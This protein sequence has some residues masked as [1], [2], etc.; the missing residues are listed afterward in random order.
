MEF[1]NLIK[2][3]FL[4]K[5]KL[6]KFLPTHEKIKEQKLLKIFGNFLH[7]R[8]IWS[9]SRKKVLG[10]VFIGIFV[11]CLPM[12]LQMVLASLLAIIFNVNLP[13]SFALIFITNPLTMPPLFFFEYQIGK[14]ILQPENPVEFNFDSMYDNF[15]DIAL[16]L[17]LG[18]IILG[19]ILA[20]VSRFIVNFLWIRTVRKDR[21]TSQNRYISEE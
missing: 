8:E 7:K 5:K 6:K 9:L 13:I 14:W 19:L 17:Y 20:F 18:S 4:P 15:D 10:G 11:A 12:P 3:A 1:K 21:K 16:C 2:R